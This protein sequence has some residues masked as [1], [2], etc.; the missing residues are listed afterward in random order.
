MGVGPDGACG[1]VSGGGDSWAHSTAAATKASA[2]ETGARTLVISAG[3]YHC[4]REPAY[5]WPINVCH[6]DLTPARR[7]ELAVQICS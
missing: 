7:P 4:S 6:M 3:W 1:G 5:S 2:I